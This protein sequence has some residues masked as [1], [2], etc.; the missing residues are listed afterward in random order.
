MRT[1]RVPS[2]HRFVRAFALAVDPGE[3]LGLLVEI[4]ALSSPDIG[5][6]RRTREALALAYDRASDL[7]D[8]DQAHT[9]SILRDVLAQPDAAAY[10]DYQA[11]DSH[12][13]AH[14]AG[15]HAEALAVVGCAFDTL[16]CRSRPWEVEP[17]DLSLPEWRKRVARLLPTRPGN[18]PLKPS[19]P[20]GPPDPGCTCSELGSP[21][22][23]A[24]DHAPWCA[25]H[26]DEAGT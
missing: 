7:K 22:A 3:D 6:V 1:L 24:G 2:E 13:A 14:L 16:G 18:T 19:T 20:H 26:H 5:I 25:L 21:A 23:L 12:R 11:P 15:E 4:G 17:D 10:L 9:I 8:W